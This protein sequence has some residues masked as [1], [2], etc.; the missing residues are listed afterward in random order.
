MNIDLATLA[1]LAGRWDL[2]PELAVYVGPEVR[3]ASAQFGLA[4]GDD[5]FRMRSGRIRATVVFPDQ[6]AEG[7]LVFGRNAATNAYF[8]AGVGGHGFGYVLNEF[9]P[10]GGW[11]PLRTEGSEVNISAGIPYEVEV[12]VLGQRTQRQRSECS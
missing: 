2:R 12:L 11:R 6:R 4:I 10:G 5:R 3:T 8:S 9:I 7:R 1:P